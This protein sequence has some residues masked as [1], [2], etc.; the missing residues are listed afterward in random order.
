MLRFLA[1]LLFV[2]SLL[3][4]AT[5]TVTSNAD[6]SDPGTLRWAMEQHGSQG[7]DNRIVFDPALAGSTI[8][9]TGTLPQVTFNTL[10]IDGRDAPGLVIDGDAGGR[11]FLV[12][13]NADGFILRNLVV[14]NSDGVFGGG[15]LRATGNGDVV[16]TITNVT[17]AECEQRPPSNGSSPAFG[18]AI[19]TEFNADGIL[20]IRNSRFIGNRVYGSENLL[21]GGA[22]YA[23]GGTVTLLGNHFELNSAENLGNASDQGG[24]VYIRDAEVGLND[25]EFL[26]NQVGGAGGAVTLNLLPTNVASVQRNLFAANVA[27]LGAAVWTGTQSIGGDVPFFNFWNNTFLSNTSSSSPGGSIYVREGQLVTRNNSWIDNTNTGSGAAHLAYNPSGAE[28]LSTWNNLFSAATTDA[29][30]TFNN[31]PP[32]TFGSAGYNLLPDGSCAINGFNDLIGDAGPFLPLGH[33]GGVTRTVP[34]A[35]LNLALDNANPAPITSTNSSLCTFTDARGVDRPGDGDAD[36]TAVCD[37]GAFEWPHEAPLFI[38]GFETG[39]LVIP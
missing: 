18:G 15:C 37:M 3:H 26:F 39:A 6:T 30:A 8:T 19:Y 28:F 2:P 34:P 20:D 5:F 33:Y 36:G 10:E 22:I 12:G 38:D 27:A 24:A 16:V 13:N 25:N 17:F 35:S 4:A 31:N 32:A 9:L 23:E 29:C 11:V 7:G 21:F 1:L 14:Q